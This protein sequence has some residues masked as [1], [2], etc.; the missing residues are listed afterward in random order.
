[1][2]ETESR[3]SAPCTLVTG[4]RRLLL[5][6]GNTAFSFLDLPREVRDK[7]YRYLLSVAHNQDGTFVWI[8]TCQYW[9]KNFPGLGLLCVNRQIRAEAWHVLVN[10]NAWISITFWGD[11]ELFSHLCSPDSSFLAS[12]PRFIAR[13]F[14]EEMRRELF[15]NA[16]INVCLGPKS[17]S[18]GKDEPRFD[19]LLVFHPRI[20]PDMVNNIAQQVG[21]LHSVHIT[22]RRDAHLDTSTSG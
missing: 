14:P 6:D 1:M 17:G 12:G 13:I 20:W 2:P 9:R 19:Q 11:F 22:C 15:S 4:M 16:V 18:K 8:S 21:E 7:V 3:V 5:G 10:D